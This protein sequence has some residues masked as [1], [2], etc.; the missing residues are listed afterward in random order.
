MPKPSR[1][2]YIIGSDTEA[3]RF[4]T[5][6]NYSSKGSTREAEARMSFHQKHIHN[7]SE[8]DRITPVI[9]LYQKAGTNE[10]IENK[11]TVVERLLRTKK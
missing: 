1:K 11:L 7:L 2:T 4:C 9:T 10:I 8:K 6:C 3:E 5:N